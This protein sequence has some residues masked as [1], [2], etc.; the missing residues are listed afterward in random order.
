MLESVVC[1]LQPGSGMTQED[2]ARIINNCAAY[3]EQAIL[4]I[5]KVRML[6]VL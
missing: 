3:S 4:F 1:L 6:K 5:A 2:A